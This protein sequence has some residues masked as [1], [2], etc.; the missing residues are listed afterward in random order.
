MS[1]ENKY[2]NEVQGLSAEALAEQAERVEAIKAETAWRKKNQAK[3]DAG[4]VARAEA[5][6]EGSKRWME[7]LRKEVIG[8]LR[9]AESVKKIVPESAPKKAA[10]PA[11]SKAD[12]RPIQA[13]AQAPQGGQQQA[14]I[15]P[16]NMAGRP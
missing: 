11:D 8:E 14:G 4:I 9:R 5:K 2:T 1:I 12:Q 15:T 3:I 13:A 6:D 10:E 16:Q 7:E